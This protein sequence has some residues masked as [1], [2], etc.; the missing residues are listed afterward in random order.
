MSY[1]DRLKKTEKVGGDYPKEPKEFKKPNCLGLLGALPVTFQKLQATET[2]YRWWLIHYQDRESV[3][4]RSAPPATEAEILDRRPD[5]NAAQTL[6]Q[7][8]QSPISA[9]SSCVHV[10][11]RGGCGEP[12]AAGLSDLPGVIRYSP[13]QGATCPAGRFRRPS[14]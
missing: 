9:C 7:A 10:T 11:G 13:D 4:V 12:V 6:H 2:S 3:Q 8:A 5:A 14:K 1:L